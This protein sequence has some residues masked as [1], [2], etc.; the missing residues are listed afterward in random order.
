[1]ISRFGLAHVV[2]ADICVWMRTVVKESIKAIAI[3]GF[4]ATED[5]LILSELRVT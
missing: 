2:A 1:M 5:A 3:T 4:G